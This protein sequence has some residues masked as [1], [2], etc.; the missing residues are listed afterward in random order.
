MKHRFL[1]QRL[2]SWYLIAVIKVIVVLVGVE[3]FIPL[4]TYLLGP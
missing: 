3:S 4:L 1:L 2:Q